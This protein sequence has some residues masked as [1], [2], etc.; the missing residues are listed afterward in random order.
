M[1]VNTLNST[2]PIDTIELETKDFE[3]AIASCRK[4]CEAAATLAGFPKEAGY[5]VLIG[6]IAKTVDNWSLDKF[7]QWTERVADNYGNT[8]TSGVSILQLVDLVS[9][10]MTEPRHR[11]IRKLERVALHSKS[12]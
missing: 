5:D 8:S 9:F 7:Q 10:L 3:R 6:C 2:I 4:D 12:S 11:V 1:I